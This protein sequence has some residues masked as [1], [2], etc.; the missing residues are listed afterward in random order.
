VTKIKESSLN[1]IILP[2]IESDPVP[3]MDVSPSKESISEK[4]P[5]LRLVTTN[6]ERF[7]MTGDVNFFCIQG[8]GGRNTALRYSRKK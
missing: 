5:P 2:R 4:T 3:T 8:T 7:K 1:L 6:I